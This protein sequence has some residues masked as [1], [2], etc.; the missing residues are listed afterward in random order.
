[1]YVANDIGAIDGHHRA[2][3]RS[4][5]HVHHGAILGD[6]DVLACEHRVAT[7]CHTRPFG[8]R[9]EP[10]E[11]GVVDAMLRV[12]DAQVGDIDDVALGPAGIVREQ[13]AQVGGTGQL[14]Q[15]RVKVGGVHRDRT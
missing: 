9:D 10:G 12:V 2:G 8:E 4:Q 5:R 11:H 3:R 1:M 7:S 6:V 15:G 13:R 14:G